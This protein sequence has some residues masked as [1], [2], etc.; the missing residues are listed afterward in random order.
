MPTVL[1][2]SK[3]LAPPWND[4]SK[5]L[6]RDVAAGLDAY[7]PVVLGDG[8]GRWRPPRGRVEPLYAA[9]S[10]YAPGLSAQLRVLRR[11]ALG[12]RES[13]WHFF[14]APNPR[15]SLA[16][17]A[18]ATV[19]RAPTVQTV[20]SRPRDL[21]GARRLLF[22]DRTVVLSRHTRDALRDAGVPDERLALVP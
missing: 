21:A 13:L 7:E 16:G 12:R 4:S 5:N 3:A 10:A 6:A 2:V 19:R 9:P 11:L 18:L 20:C 1:L 8:A 14:F 15:S 22:A 17:R